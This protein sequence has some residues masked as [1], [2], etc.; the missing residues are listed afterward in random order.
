MVHF[1]ESSR[2]GHYI[3]NIQSVCGTSIGGMGFG[4][5]LDL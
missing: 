2:P 5:N 3:H 1:I 4:G